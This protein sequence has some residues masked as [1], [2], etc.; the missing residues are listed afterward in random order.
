MASTSKSLAQMNKSQ[1]GI[2]ATKEIFGPR[3]VGEIMPPGTLPRQE[4]TKRSSLPTEALARSGGW[5]LF[6]IFGANE[7][8]PDVP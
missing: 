7:Q 6:Q 3:N 4:R 5:G 2:C 8:N 1:D